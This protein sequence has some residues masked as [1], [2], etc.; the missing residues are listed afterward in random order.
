MVTEQL[1]KYCDSDVS[2]HAGLKQAL[3]ADMEELFELLAEE[4]D[5]HNVMHSTVVDTFHPL[6][7]N[8]EQ[9]LASE[10]G[11][12]SGLNGVQN[13]V[14]RPHVEDLL[15]EDGR[16]SRKIGDLVERLQRLQGRLN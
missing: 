14:S 4:R 16:F 7:K 12:D 15:C 13:N 2:N 9:L 10:F 1:R 3:S 6:V 8:I 5:N 11:V